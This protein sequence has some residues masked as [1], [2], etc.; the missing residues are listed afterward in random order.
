MTAFRV[1][2]DIVYY[3]ACWIVN[4]L[5]LMMLGVVMQKM[6]DKSDDMIYSLD[7]IVSSPVRSL[8]SSLNKHTKPSVRGKKRR[9][10]SR[11]VNSREANDN[12]PVDSNYKSSDSFSTTNWV[13]VVFL[14]TENV[15]NDLY[16]VQ[17]GRE[18]TVGVTIVPEWTPPSPPITNIKG[19]VEASSPKR[20][21]PTSFIK[22]IQSDSQG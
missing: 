2:L 15:N 1:G 18:D 3:N 7:P 11:T 5:L 6:P 4:Y 21:L 9:A 8:L 12:V 10:S 14:Q 19:Q 22:Y 20:L 16:N 17:G 13:E